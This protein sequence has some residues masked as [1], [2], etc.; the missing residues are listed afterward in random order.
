MFLRFCES[1]YISRYFLYFSDASSTICFFAAG[2]I[3]ERE[4]RSSVPENTQSAVV[5][6]LRKSID[7]AHPKV[8]E[9]VSAGYD[10]TASI[11]AIRLCEDVSEAMNYLDT[12]DTKDQEEVEHGSEESNMWK[13]L[14]EE[15]D[16]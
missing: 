8:Q 13:E 7:G 5:T 11:E 16:V 9:L 2:V 10:P 14:D 6:V 3:F 15:L 1:I 4:D 12:M